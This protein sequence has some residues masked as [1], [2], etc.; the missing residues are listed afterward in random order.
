MARIRIEVDG[1]QW[2][3]ADVD[4]WQAPPA[5]PDNPTR[6]P[7][8]ALPKQVRELLAKAMGKAMEQ[9]TGFKVRVDV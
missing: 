5:L 4:G 2:F 9:A 8:S 3:D 6:M 7:V 1:R